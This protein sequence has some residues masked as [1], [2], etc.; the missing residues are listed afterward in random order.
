MFDDDDDFLDDYQNDSKNEHTC[1]NC[2]TIT[3]EEGY[4]D[5]CSSELAL[6]YGY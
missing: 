2:G 1:P 3:Y 5:N 4:C 6:I